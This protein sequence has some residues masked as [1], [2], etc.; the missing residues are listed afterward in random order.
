MSVPPDDRDPFYWRQEGS[1]ITWVYGR[2]LGGKWV[3]R[4]PA[5]PEDPLLMP[6]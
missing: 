2:H 1:G 5:K 4:G 6:D 3:V